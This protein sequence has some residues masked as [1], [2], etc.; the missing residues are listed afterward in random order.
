MILKYLLG[1][2]QGVELEGEITVIDYDHEIVTYYPKDATSEKTY[3]RISYPTKTVK[4]KDIYNIKEL[5]IC[6]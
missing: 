2:R 6:R 5:K 3:W 1:V 4:L